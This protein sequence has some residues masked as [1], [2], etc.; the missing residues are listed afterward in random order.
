MLFPVAD[1]G[2][3]GF[4]DRFSI[5]DPSLAPAGH[6]LVQAEMPL[7]DGEPAAAA[8]SRLERLADLGLPGWR[9]R[10]T[11]RRDATAHHRTGALGLPGLTWRGPAPGAR[12]DGGLRAAATPGG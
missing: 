8:L 1:V 5:G 7:R 3:G 11:W 9:D 12:G 4:L 2:E 6:S 10:G